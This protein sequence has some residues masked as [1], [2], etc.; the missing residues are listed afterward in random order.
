M[1]KSRSKK[2]LSEGGCNIPTLSDFDESISQA[3]SIDDSTEN[4]DE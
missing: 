4:E 3:S 1:R 2:S